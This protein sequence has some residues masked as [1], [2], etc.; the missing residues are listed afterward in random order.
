M[1]NRRASKSNTVGF[2]G[3]FLDKAR[4]FGRKYIAK[5]RVEKKSIIIGYFE[6]K[7]VAA[8]AYDKAARE[9]HGEYART[10]FD[11][12]FNRVV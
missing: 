10:N 12:D 9:F 11:E 5:I 1:Y 7:I 6:S 8:F 4:K 2:K 3:V